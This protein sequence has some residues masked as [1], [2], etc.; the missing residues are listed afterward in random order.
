[1][2]QVV[3][4]CFFFVVVVVVL[5][6]VVVFLMKQVLFVQSFIYADTAVFFICSLEYYNYTL[7]HLFYIKN[8]NEMFV[9]RVNT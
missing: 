1:M 4:G 8:C 5:F 2:K 7:T 9:F 6:F 3:L